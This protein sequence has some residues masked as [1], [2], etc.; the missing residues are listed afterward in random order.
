MMHH[1]FWA[2]YTE[3]SEFQLAMFT[4]KGKE[5]SMVVILP[6]KRNGLAEIEKKPSRK[7]LEEALALTRLALLQVTLPKFKITEAFNLSGELVKLG[8]KDAF[9][10]KIA[11]FKGMEMEAHRKDKDSLFISEVVHQAFVEVD[12]KGTE[13]ATATGGTMARPSSLRPPDPP[14]ILF[15]ADHPFLFL[16]RH[17]TTGSILFMGRIAEPRGR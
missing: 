10:P 12:E 5:N 15:R 14:P 1:T 13:A 6:K 8:M 3:N 11:D 16:L 9:L 7:V 4:Y 2:M 17:N